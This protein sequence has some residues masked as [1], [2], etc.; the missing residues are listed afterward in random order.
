M[1]PV[2]SSPVLPRENEGERLVV[3]L[4]GVQDVVALAR[5]SSVDVLVPAF[6][7]G[8]GVEVL[9]ALA[10]VDGAGRRWIATSEFEGASGRGRVALRE[11]TSAGLSAP[12]VLFEGP[13]GSV[14]R[15]LRYQDGF[16][17]VRDVQRGLSHRFPAGTSR[18]A[19]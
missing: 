18:R 16:L 6:T 19:S 12:A 11:S 13:P 8:R 5:T 17:S 15:W 4:T 1:R 7:A 3:L 2:D 14:L 9:E 10:I